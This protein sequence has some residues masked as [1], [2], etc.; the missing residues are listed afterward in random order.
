MLIVIDLALQR[1]TGLPLKRIILLSKNARLYGVAIGTRL[2]PLTFLRTMWRPFSRRVPGGVGP[3]SF[4]AKSRK[5]QEETIQTKHIQQYRGTRQAV[6]GVRYIEGHSAYVGFLRREKAAAQ[7]LRQAHPPE[8][9]SRRAQIA[10]RGI[11]AG[12]RGG[13]VQGCLHYERTACLR[14][15][16]GAGKCAQ[17]HQ[18]KSTIQRLHE[19]KQGQSTPCSRGAVRAMAAPA[20]LHPKRWRTIID[21]R[22]VQR[23]THSGAGVHATAV[24][25]ADKM[26]QYL[27]LVLENQTLHGQRQNPPR[28]HHEG[29]QQKGATRNPGKYCAYPVRFLNGVYYRRWDRQQRAPISCARRACCQRWHNRR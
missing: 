10:L 8:A 1:R 6:R 9:T 5:D 26:Q 14:A 18:H 21:E 23:V 7:G 25:K 27:L 3:R 20:H 11:N 12:G 13:G 19:I 15:L 28:S 22:V 24:I 4:V 2:P 17:T 16:S 29:K